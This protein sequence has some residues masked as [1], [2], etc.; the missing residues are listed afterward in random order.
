ML[1]PEQRPI[2]AEGE[3]DPATVNARLALT[4]R[5]LIESIRRYE[6][7]LALALD[8]NAAYPRLANPRQPVDEAEAN[9]RFLWRRL[10]IEADSAFESAEEN[11]ASRLFAP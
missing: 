3:S 4:P 6:D 11:L 9:E 7:A 10:S 8:V 1:S 5:L 2:L